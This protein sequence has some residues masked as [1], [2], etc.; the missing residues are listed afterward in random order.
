MLLDV[1][2]STLA[3]T[4]QYPA[5]TTPARLSAP[6]SGRRRAVVSASLIRALH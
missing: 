3:L 4:A 1:S 6:V 2:S 5:A